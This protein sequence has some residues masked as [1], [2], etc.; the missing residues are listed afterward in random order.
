MDAVYEL[1]SIIQRY[2]RKPAEHMWEHVAKWLFLGRRSSSNFSIF[3]D[4][5]IY[6]FVGVIKELEY[7]PRPPKFFFLDP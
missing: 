6:H 5:V 3:P 1:K 2:E 4:E 7:L